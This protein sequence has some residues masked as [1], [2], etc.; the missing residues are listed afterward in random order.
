MQPKQITQ[1]ELCDTAAVFIGDKTT[2]CNT[3]IKAKRLITYWY[4]LYILEEL[5]KK[6]CYSEQGSNFGIS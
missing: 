6:W 4:S 5:G 2:R 3:L 1:K